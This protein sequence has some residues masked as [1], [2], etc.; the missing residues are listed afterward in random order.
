MG[1]GYKDF[2]AG[3]VLAAAD[4]D[5]YLMRQ[6]VMTFADAAARDTA[7]AAVLDEGMVAYLED[8]DLITVY[9]GSAWVDILGEYQT[10]TPTWANLTVGNGTT[11]A[12]Y[13][14]QGDVVHFELRLNFGS[15]TAITGSVI[16]YYPVTPYDGHQA[17][18]NIMVQAQYGSAPATNLPGRGQQGSGTPKIEIRFINT[19]GTYAELDWMNATVPFTWA[20]SDDLYV[21][22]SYRA[23]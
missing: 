20:S 8:T 7:L 22:G 10:W 13:V 16:L 6:T 23:A 14:Q 12:W 21:A 15:T 18:N 17:A 5:G 19:S 3:N 11:Y 9:N 2:E 1:S 4:V